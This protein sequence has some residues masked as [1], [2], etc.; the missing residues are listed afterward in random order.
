MSRA[1]SGNFEQFFPVG[2]AWI[3]AYDEIVYSNLP[4]KRKK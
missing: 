2:Y 1:F 3:H 4:K